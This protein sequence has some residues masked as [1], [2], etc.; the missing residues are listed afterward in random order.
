MT[1]KNKARFSSLNFHFAFLMLI[2][3]AGCSSP[4]NGEEV[5]LSPT[6]VGAEISD[7]TTE[8]MMPT[9]TNTPIPMPTATPPYHDLTNEEKLARSQVYVDEASQYSDEVAWYINGDDDRVL[10]WYW[11][12][13][14]EWKTTE[15][16]DLLGL[17][18]SDL[19]IY[20]ETLPKQTI[21]GFENFDG[22]L[23]MV[24]D[25]VETVFP[26]EIFVAGL[27]N[28]SM[29]YLMA[30]GQDRL[31]DEVIDQLQTVFNP[32]ASDGE[33]IQ[34]DRLGG[35]RTWGVFMPG[36]YVN[37]YDIFPLYLPNSGSPTRDVA[38]YNGIKVGERPTSEFVVPIFSPETSDFMFFLN[39]QKASL[40]QSLGFEYSPS[41]EISA[42][43][44]STGGKTAAF[45]NGEFAILIENVYPESTHLSG[46][47]TRVIG[48]GDPGI[49]EVPN[50]ETILNART[51][52]EI[53]AA[54]NETRMIF[55]IAGRIM[56]PE[57]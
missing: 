8:T 54:L 20:G 52:A 51:E 12:F 38:G 26:A 44:L 22:S 31:G 29:R 2:F 13:N 14:Q 6:N 57:N 50:I 28:V 36:F 37:A 30:M 19:D 47:D 18:L 15:S 10:P 53:F 49:G 48:N 5:F 56:Y 34:Y 4:E 23:V 7:H 35:M 42:D 25:G 27:G 21:P 40:S 1:R 16:V 11:S 41:G 46:G 43:T 9:A 45:R 24:R 17:P 3:L 39:I 55:S 32:E 33:K